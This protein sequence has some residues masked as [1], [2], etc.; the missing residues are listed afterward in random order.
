LIKKG[1]QWMLKGKNCT[2]TLK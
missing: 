1:F 2:T